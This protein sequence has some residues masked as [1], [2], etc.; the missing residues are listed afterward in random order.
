MGTCLKHIISHIW[1][2]YFCQIWKRR[3]PK[4]PEDPSNEIF[5]ILKM[6]INGPV[7]IILG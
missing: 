2:S 1:T 3:A 4:N 7:N 6:G 5:K